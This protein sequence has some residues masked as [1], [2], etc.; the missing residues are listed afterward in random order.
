MSMYTNKTPG[1]ESR[2]TVSKKKQQNL[3]RVAN[4]NSRPNS[5]A[6][7]RVGSRAN[8]D[9]EESDNDH[10][11]NHDDF[12]DDDDHTTRNHAELTWEAQ[13]KETIEELYEKRSR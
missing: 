5:R 6:G 9:N 1:N 2:K 7:S 8:S 13:L 4:T 12:D 11:N 10:D 3:D